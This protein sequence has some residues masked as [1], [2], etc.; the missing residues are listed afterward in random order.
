MNYRDSKQG[1]SLFKDTD[2]IMQSKEAL[3]DYEIYFSPITLPTPVPLLKVVEAGVENG[4]M[5]N[6]HLVDNN[7]V[8]F[9]MR[10][11]CP[12]LVRAN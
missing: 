6:Y 7:C 3:E 8:T 4:R 1:E 2:A 5:G 10:I 11:V 12:Q 9:V